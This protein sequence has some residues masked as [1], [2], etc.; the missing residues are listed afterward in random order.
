MCEP[1][2]R[3]VDD[4]KSSKNINSDEPT[5]IVFETVSAEMAVLEENDKFDFEG[6]IYKIYD[7]SS[8]SYL[9]RLEEITKFY[10]KRDN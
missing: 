10:C 7:K 3:L 8:K 1:Y 6:K 2:L 4:L 9:A 5:F